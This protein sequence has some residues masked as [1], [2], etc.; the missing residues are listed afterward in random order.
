MG[1]FCEER[2]RGEGDVEGAEGDEEVEGGG[3]GLPEG[4]GVEGD[5][6]KG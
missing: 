6:V 3:G 2:V 4:F 1:R 5:E